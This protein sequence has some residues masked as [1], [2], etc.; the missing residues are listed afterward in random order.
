MCNLGECGRDVAL[1][2]LYK[3][4]VSTVGNS[5]SCLRK[6]FQFD[7]DPVGMIGHDA[8]FVHLYIA[9]VFRDFLPVRCGNLTQLRQDH[10]C[11]D[12]L[13]K[14]GFP[15]PGAEGYK[16]TA[17]ICVVPPGQACGRNAV[18]VF[19]LGTF[20][21]VLWIVHAYG[22]LAC[23]FQWPGGDRLVNL[24]HQAKGLLQCNHHTLVM[25]DLS[26]R[27]NLFAWRM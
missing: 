20:T 12:H 10:F 22:A 14:N 13:A 8:E 7:E 16:I 23:L 25:G 2:R 17:G 11:V 4:N 15:L 24:G 6:G 18:M 5:A 9:V 19:E 26:N 21:F 3:G 1:Q 27:F